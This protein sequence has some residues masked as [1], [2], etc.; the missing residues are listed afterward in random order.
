MRG[1]L[2]ALAV[3]LRDKEL[4]TPIEYEVRRASKPIMDT[5]GERKISY[6]Y[7]ESNHDSSVIQ[8]IA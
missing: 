2:D 4:D 7:R 3:L 8:L 5:L 6:R 1:Y